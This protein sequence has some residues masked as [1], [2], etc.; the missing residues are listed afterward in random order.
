MKIGSLKFAKKF[1][2]SPKIESDLM[3]GFRQSNSSNCEGCPG[4]RDR[5]S[6][7]AVAGTLAST[8][9]AN[10]ESYVLIEED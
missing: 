4:I 8:N 5:I 3:T 2:L 6:V 1:S 7:E 10:F 9:F